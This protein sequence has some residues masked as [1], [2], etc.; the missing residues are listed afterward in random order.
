MFE[1]SKIAFAIIP[2]RISSK[3]CRRT[4]AY[5]ARQQGELLSLLVLCLWVSLKWRVPTSI[6]YDFV[7]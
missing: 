5:V 4:D 6:V 2:K 1:V 3:A 7:N